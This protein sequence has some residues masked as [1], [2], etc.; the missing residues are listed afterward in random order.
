MTAHQF[1]VIGNPIAHS[2]SP[3]IHQAFATQF[4]HTIQYQA[5]CLSVVE[6]Q[7]QL[8]QLLHH[9]LKGFNVTVPFKEKVWQ[10]VKNKSQRAH[11]AQAVNTVLIE[12]DGL[13]YGENTD[14]IGLC[15]DLLHNHQL[16]LQGKHILILGAGGA[17]KGV[18]LPLLATGPAQITICNRTE[19]KALDLVNQFRSS[20]NIDSIRPHTTSTQYYD[21]IINASSASL[22]RTLPSMPN[23]VIDN[24]TVLYDMM[25]GKAMPYF[26]QWGKQQG[27]H[28]LIDGLGMLVEQ[29]AEAYQ[30]WHGVRP[31]TTKL[32]SQL[33]YDLSMH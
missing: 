3:Q 7:Q 33:R 12:E 11:A 31:E 28:T 4:G 22:N 16:N 6:W 9:G 25:Y 21:L 18:I 27:I 15:R 19:K 1:A 26:L 14:G 23:I 10:W 24:N 32:L 17:A 29:A 5:Y 8:E 20:G 30:L 13:T 2:L